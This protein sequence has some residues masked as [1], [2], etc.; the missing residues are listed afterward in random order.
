MADIHEAGNVL[1]VLH[2]MCQGDRPSEAPPS[3]CRI[4][5]HDCAAWIVVEHDGRVYARHDQ[6]STYVNESVERFEECR[7]AFED[8]WA[9][10]D[11]RR[12]A[13]DA[14]AAALSVELREV[15]FR[16]DPTLSGQ[17]FS[18]W[19]GVIDAVLL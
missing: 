19:V 13:D 12:L 2:E 3:G 1:S 15:I 9:D 5:G 18:W 11:L 8:R 16:V 10:V 4:L 7:A 14:T 6:T 17:Q